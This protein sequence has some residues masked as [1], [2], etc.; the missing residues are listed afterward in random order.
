VS[1]GLVFVMFRIVACGLKYMI[2]G[3]VDLWTLFEL[4]V[5]MFEMF[6][7]LCCMSYCIYVMI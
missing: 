1:F 4:Y 3:L 6:E 5:M 7:L 2:F